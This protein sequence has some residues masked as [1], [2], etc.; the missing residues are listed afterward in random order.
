MGSQALALVQARKQLA[1]EAGAPR[2]AR[3]GTALGSKSVRPL[4]GRIRLAPSAEARGLQESYGGLRLFPGL[5][6]GAA[7]VSPLPG[8]QASQWR[9]GLGSRFHFA[10]S[11]S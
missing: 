8:G 7:R 6:D 1:L 3:S 5:L 2:E 11:L 10:L 4:L 9:S